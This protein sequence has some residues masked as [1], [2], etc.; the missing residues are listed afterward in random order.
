[1]TNP[2]NAYKE[3]RIRTAGPGQIIIMLYAEAV[4]QCDNA[5]AYLGQDYK[6]KPDLI[7]KI[8]AAMGRVQDVITEL[9][10]SLDFESGGEIAK[11]LF[12]LYIFFNR[13]IMEANIAKDAKRIKSV[14]D[15]LD[16]LRGAW[17]E[18]VGKAGMSAN[19]AA[20]VGIN[21]AG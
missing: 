21:I 3:T 8:N 11:N 19:P 16:D 17:V 9:M 4:K 7:E 6:K 5:L 13:E 14:R 18:T 2:I 10:A 12:S 15:M 1:M 20:R